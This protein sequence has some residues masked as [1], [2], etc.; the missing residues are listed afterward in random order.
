MAKSGIDSRTIAGT[1]MAMVGKPEE[2]T[3]LAA[4]TTVSVLVGG[5][6]KGMKRD[7]NGIPNFDEWSFEEVTEALEYALKIT[8]MG[9]L[10]AR[11]KN[12]LLPAVEAISA[13]V[14]GGDESSKP[15]TDGTNE[16]LSKS[17]DSTDSEETT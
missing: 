14:S 5:S 8:D 13:A 17:A 10:G 2:W 1:L 12:L 3:V 4:P 6:I 7:E 15:K 9:R 11:L 16:S